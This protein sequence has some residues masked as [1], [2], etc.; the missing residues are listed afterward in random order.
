MYEMCRVIREAGLITQFKTQNSGKMRVTLP[1]GHQIT[2]GYM[3]QLLVF[4]RTR[5]DVVEEL[6]LRF[7]TEFGILESIVTFLFM[8]IWFRSLII[9]GSTCLFRQFLFAANS[10]IRDCRHGHF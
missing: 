2:F 9:A 8:F 7:M 6:R 1:N 3:R 4:A 5:P 10:A